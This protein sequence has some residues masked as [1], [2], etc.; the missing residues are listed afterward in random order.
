MLSGQPEIIQNEAGFSDWK[1]HSEVALDRPV[2]EIRWCY[3]GGNTNPTKMDIGRID[4]LE[5]REGS[6]IGFVLPD[7]NPGPAVPEGTAVAIVVRSEVAVEAGRSVLIRLLVEEGE[8]VIDPN[9]PN[10]VAEESTPGRLV[11]GLPL[12]GDGTTLEACAEAVD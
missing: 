3:V 11:L 1:Q 12:T 4:R 9:G 10:V 5:V 7:P 2:P 8:R 6:R